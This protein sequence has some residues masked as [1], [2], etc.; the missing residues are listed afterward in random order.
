MISQRFPLELYSGHRRTGS[1]S[2]VQINLKK[3]F[4]LTPYLVWDIEER[5]I[6]VIIPLR[7]DRSLKNFVSLIL[8][9]LLPRRLKSSVRYNS[10]S[11]DHK[12][13]A[14]HLAVGQLHIDWPTR[15]KTSRN[16]F[17]KK[18]SD[19]NFRYKKKSIQISA[20]YI[21][22]LCK[23]KLFAVKKYTKYPCLASSK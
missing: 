16:S 13:T 9:D 3:L 22:F 15:W 21:N 2:P 1:A 6:C 5:P 20:E 23:S 4:S 11:T 7:A 19:I 8:T 18:I 17:E 10:C 14:V 12:V